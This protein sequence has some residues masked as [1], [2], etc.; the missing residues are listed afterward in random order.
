MQKR[1][2]MLASY[3]RSG[4]TYLRTIL[5]HCFKLPSASVYQQDLLGA[6]TLEKYVGHV[7]IAPGELQ[8]WSGKKGIQAVKTHKYPVDDTP[9]IYVVRDGRAAS[10]S[11]WEFTHRKITLDELIEGR[12]QYGTW[13]DHLAAWRP[14]ERAGTLLLRYE[15]MAENL[16]LVLEEIS[17]YLGL[18]ILARK[19]PD[20]DRIAD[21][22]LIWVRKPTDWRQCI[23]EPQLDLF[24]KINGDM[25]RRMGYAV[26]AGGG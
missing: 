15:D 9:A 19:V 5:W 26:H 22:A 25:M 17:R 23:S 12:H 20:R 18:R 14:W 21:I 7:E 13:A 2:I 6:K 10:I 8:N 16:P 3:P 1:L 4:N 11:L 24:E